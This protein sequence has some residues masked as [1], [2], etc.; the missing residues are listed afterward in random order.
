MSAFALSPWIFV[1][2]V[3]RVV[4]LVVVIVIVSRNRFVVHQS[5]LS[6]SCL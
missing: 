6:G 4:I 5:F 3:V 2:S 1:G